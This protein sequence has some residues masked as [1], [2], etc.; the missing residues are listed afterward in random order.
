MTV[1]IDIR[2][3][4]EDWLRAE[5]AAEAIC[6]AAAKAAVTASGL[7][8]AEVSLVLSDDPAVASLNSTYRGKSGPTN[9]LS[10]PAGDGVD[11]SAAAERDGPPLLLGDVV[12]AFETTAAE[13]A[14]TGTA[15][16]DHLR[17][18]VVHGILHLVGY[19]HETDADA[20]VMEGLEVEIL[21]EFGVDDPYR[22]EKHFVA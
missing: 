3:D 8:S 17:H 16:A 5:P 13:A 19:D 7:A 1:Q 12:I 18:L 21:R 15:L 14:A 6:S 9:V 20:A 10:F 4:S 11:D 22:D 2:I